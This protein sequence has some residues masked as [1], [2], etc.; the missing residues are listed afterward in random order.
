M[1][2]PAYGGAVA[3]GVNRDDVRKGA[4][5]L[6][7]PLEDHIRVCIDAMR[8]IAPQLGLAGA[9]STGL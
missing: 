2:S 5:E 9:G 1:L 3:R 8:S 6:G 4:E 7:V